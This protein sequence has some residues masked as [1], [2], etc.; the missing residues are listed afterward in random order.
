[1]KENKSNKNS[2]SNNKS[3]ESEL[4]SINSLIEN[5]KEN[6]SLINEKK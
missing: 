1:M 2:N 6:N 3:K 5:K 4:D